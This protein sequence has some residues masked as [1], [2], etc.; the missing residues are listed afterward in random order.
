MDGSTRHMMRSAEA[1]DGRASSV[2][3]ECEAD[4]RASVDAWFDN[5]P[6]PWDK[7]YE[8]LKRMDP[9]HLPNT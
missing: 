5:L 7:I 8:D 4:V 3:A 1:M 9:K 2:P 6:A